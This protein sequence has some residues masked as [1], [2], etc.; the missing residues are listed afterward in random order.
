MDTETTPRSKLQSSTAAPGG[1]WVTWLSV[2]TA[3]LASAAARPANGGLTRQLVDIAAP[4]TAGASDQAASSPRPGWGEILKRLY[5]SINDNRILAVAAGITFYGLLAIFPAIAALLAI[6]GLF[7][8]VGSV[9]KQLSALQGV[10]PGGAIEIIG[11]QVK[12]IASKGGSTLGLAF[13]VSF[14]TSLWSANAG[15]KALIDGL[16]IAYGR[17]EKRGFIKLNLASL[18]FTFA[19]ICA[20]VVAMGMVVVAPVVLGYIGLG[21]AGRLISLGRW[22][23]LLAFVILALAVLYRFAP[24]PDG[25]KWRWITPGSLIA[26]IIWLAA[27]AAFSYYAS[28]FGSYNATYGSLGA[29]VGLMTWIWISVIVVLVGAELN[30][31]LEAV[32]KEAGRRP[33]AQAS[34][35]PSP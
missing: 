18:G 35:A 25:G 5:R 9:Q 17:T 15:M 10:L 3:V 14:A 13:A 20:L 28:H 8:D 7:A 16:N 1:F 32:E 24:S 23:A 29:A 4:Q 11:D 31:Q 22:P 6:Y 26:A 19:A 30:G 27:S 21:D 12:R 2:F 34:A 33:A